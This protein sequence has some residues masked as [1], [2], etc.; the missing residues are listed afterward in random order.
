[1]P[2]EW[3]FTWLTVKE[4]SMTARSFSPHDLSPRDTRSD[5]EKAYGLGSGNGRR[6]P[7]NLVFGRVFDGIVWALTIFALATI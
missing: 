6:M 4:V 1:M 7:L 2:V 3:A 5:S